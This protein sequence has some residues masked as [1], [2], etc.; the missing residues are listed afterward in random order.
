[1]ADILAVQ[2]SVCCQPKAKA[3]TQDSS[4]EAAKA[5]RKAKKVKA[6]SRRDAETQRKSK[7]EDARLLDA[8]ALRKSNKTQ[9]RSPGK[10][11][12]PGVSRRSSPRSRMR[13]TRLSGLQNLF[14]LLPLPFSASPR[15]CERTPL[16]CLSFAPL[17]LRESCPEF[18]PLTLP[19]S[20]SL[21]LCEKTPLT[22]FSLAPLRLS[23]SCPEPLLL[24]FDQ[25]ARE[26]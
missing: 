4:R 25:V 1:M 5:P 16:T 9:P 24:P 3:R 14:K 23:E 19:F 6:C 26:R 18:Q 8:K 13:A 7:L 11:S 2:A 12:A 10:Q 22:R 21:R 20:A 15:L 17:R